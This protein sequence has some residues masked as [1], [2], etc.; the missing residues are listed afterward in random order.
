MTFL[1][2]DVNSSHF[3]IICDYLTFMRWIVGRGQAVVQLLHLHR[4]VVTLAN[5]VYFLEDHPGFN[6]NLAA[7]MWNYKPVKLESVL[8][9][10]LNQLQEKTGAG[11]LG[12]AAG[13]FSRVLNSYMIS[14][15]RVFVIWSEFQHC[16]RPGWT[17]TCLIRLCNANERLVFS[18]RLKLDRFF[19]FVCIS[20][21]DGLSHGAVST[22]SSC[23]R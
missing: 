6:Q 22:N 15:I 23:I 5:L 4:S 13:R 7:M 8:W 21:A 20:Q 14:G 3:L 12:T 2:W 19:P 11:Q 17:W 18:L 10:W 16:L 1:R 9:S